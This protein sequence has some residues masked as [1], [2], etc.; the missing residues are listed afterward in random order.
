MSAAMTP[1]LRV[2]VTG[3]ESTGKTR[4]AAQ[5]AAR[6]AAPISPENARLYLDSIGRP[7]AASDVEPIAR[8][9]IA[10]EDQAIA[11]AAGLAVHDTD[12][13]STVVYARHYYAACPAWIEQAARAR[14]AQLYLLCH[15][16]VPWIADG[17]QRD[18]GWM[19]EELHALFVEALAELGAQVVDVRGD[20]ASRHELAGRAVARLVAGQPAAS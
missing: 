20:W 17:L 9:Q 2:V 12:L 19:R 3:S 13:V 4:L 11:R 18:R 1:V 5:L 15:P 14:R 6:F 10:G 8:G 16:D 7:L